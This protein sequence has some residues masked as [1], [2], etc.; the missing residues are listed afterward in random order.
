MASFAFPEESLICKMTA[1]ILL[2]LIST[3]SKK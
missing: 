1:A 3:V 2:V